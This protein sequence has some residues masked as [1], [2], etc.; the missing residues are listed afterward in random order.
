MIDKS[1]VALVE[2]R[3]GGYCEVCGLP[4]Q[5]GMALH[6]RKLKSRGGKDTVANLIRVHHGCHNLNTDSV[7]SNP[8]WAEH[9]G[10]M[11]ASWQDP[12]EAPMHMPDGS[13]VLLKNDGS[14]HTLQ[15]GQQ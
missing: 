6:H 11:V 3:A 10:Y 7:H 15:G 14:L 1:I 13:I 2:Q 5:E 8:N 4:A 12:E 9:K